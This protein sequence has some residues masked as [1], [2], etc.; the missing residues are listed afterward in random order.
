[1]RVTNSFLYEGQ[2]ISKKFRNETCYWWWYCLFTYKG[3]QPHCLV[4][5]VIRFCALDVW[6]VTNYACLGGMLEKRR[7]AELELMHKIVMDGVSLHLNQDRKD[8]TS[9][10]FIYPLLNHRTVHIIG[11]VGKKIIIYTPILKK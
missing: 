2:I 4:N 9:Q 11:H 6:P 8:A 1:M 10:M 3:I 5:K 7:K